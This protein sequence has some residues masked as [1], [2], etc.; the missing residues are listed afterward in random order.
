ML[1]PPSRPAN[2]I[3][4]NRSND[5][6]IRGTPPAEWKQ[7]GLIWNSQRPHWGWW[8]D[9]LEKEEP[10]LFCWLM[11]SRKGCRSPK[12]TTKNAGCLGFLGP[13]NAP[14]HRCWSKTERAKDVLPDRCH[15]NWAMALLA[16]WFPGCAMLDTSRSIGWYKN[17]CS[18]VI[19]FSGNKTG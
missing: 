3:A 13:R 2:R 19:P 17:K 6:E 4:E 1:A 11:I 15:E 7:E 10:P 9:V 5:S 12:T 14:I 16:Y 18:Q 8:N